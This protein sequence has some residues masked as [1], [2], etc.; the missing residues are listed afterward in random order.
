ME[1]TERVVEAYVRYVKR[2]ATIP[3]IK[4]PGQNEIDLLA[5]DPMT[6]DRYHIEVSVSISDGFSKLTNKPYDRALAKQRVAGPSQRRTLGFFVERKFAPPG[7]IQTLQQYGFQ[8]GNYKQIIV[9]WGWE[10]GLVDI[11]QAEGIELWDFRDIMNDISSY[12][13]QKKTYYIDDTLRTLQLFCLGA[14]HTNG[15]KK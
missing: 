12:C 9:S 4:C 8:P 15:G 11:A 5:I 14:N 3:N 7:V 13:H 10:D 2:W 1:T 6:L